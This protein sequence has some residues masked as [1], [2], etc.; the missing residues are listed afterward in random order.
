MTPPE[1]NPQHPARR[2]HIPVEGVIES[3]GRW[4]RGSWIFRDRTL[5]GLATL[6]DEAFR[7]PGTNMRFG[8]DGIIGLVPGLGDVLAGILSARDPLRCVDSR[9]AIRN[10][11]AD[12]REHWN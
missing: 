6:L 10:A 8:I 3:P 12:D 4:E 1:A 5:E 9:R 11:D 2:A 7:I